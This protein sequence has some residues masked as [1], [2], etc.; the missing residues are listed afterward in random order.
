MIR[1]C[2]MLISLT[3]WTLLFMYMPR[4]PAWLLFVLAGITF[5]VYLFQLTM[6][7]FNALMLFF[8]SLIWLG[9]GSAMKLRLIWQRESLPLPSG[10]IYRTIL[11]AALALSAF[12]TFSNYRLVLSFLQ[13]R[14][15]LEINKLVKTPRPSIKEQWKRFRKRR[16]RETELELILG[17]EVSQ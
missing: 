10:F 3:T 9:I 11:I 16:N 17:E 13:R 8:S 4:W 2:W 14:G 5:A 6:Q 15:N 7:K 1:F 12:L